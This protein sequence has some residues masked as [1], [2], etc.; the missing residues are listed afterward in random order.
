ME[1]PLLALLGLRADQFD[2]FRHFPADFVL[3]QFAQRD[4]GCPKVSHVGNER[5]AQTAATGIQLAHPAR[6]QVHQDVRVA[7][8]LVGSFA[9]FSVH[10]LF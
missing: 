4:V 6:N 1:L 5:T 2:R 3:Q 9:K 10:N 7:N 8:L